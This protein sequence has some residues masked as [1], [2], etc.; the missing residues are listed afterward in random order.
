[1]SSYFID[2]CF[3][4]FD[5]SF[6]LSDINWGSSTQAHVY[7]NALQNTQKLIRVTEHVKNFRSLSCALCYQWAP[8]FAWSINQLRQWYTQCRFLLSNQFFLI[9]NS[10]SWRYNISGDWYRVLI[11]FKS[12]ETVIYTLHSIVFFCL[13]N[14]SYFKF[15]QLNELHFGWLISSAYWFQVSQVG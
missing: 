3:H 8:K 5:H 10:F 11:G 4:G 12:T 15:I 2:A 6:L 14:F 9:L 13:I 1:M 7:R